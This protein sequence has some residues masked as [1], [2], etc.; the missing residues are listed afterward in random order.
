MSLVFN[1]NDSNSP[2]KDFFWSSKPTPG[3]K[4]NTISEKIL[5]ADNIKFSRIFLLENGDSK[6]FVKNFSDQPIN[7][8][9]FIIESKDK[10]VHRFSD[11]ILQPNEEESIILPDLENEDVF[12]SIKNPLN[13]VEN[14]FCF[15]PNKKTFFQN[16]F[17]QILKEKFINK[18]WA[19]EI[20]DSCISA[21][22][23]WGVISR[24]TQGNSR[25]D[26]KFDAGKSFQKSSKNLV[27][28]EIFPNPS[29]K[30]EEK[31]FLELQCLAE[32]CDLKNFFLEISNKPVNFP[33]K[34]LSF[35]EFFLV[36]DIKIKNS[37]LK[38]EIFDFYSQEKEKIIIKKIPENK[39]W[40][41]FSNY[42]TFTEISTP[43]KENKMSKIVKNQEK[44]ITEKFYDNDGDS[45][46]DEIEKEIGLDLKNEDLEKKAIFQKIEDFI[47]KN[48]QFEVTKK[49][50]KMQISGQTMPFSEINF[51]FS[52]K[53]EKIFVK[54]GRRGKFLVF[55]DQSDYQG[56]YFINLVI[57]VFNG[58]KIFMEKVANFE[59]EKKIKQSPKLT[60]SNQILKLEIVKVLPNPDGKDAGNEKIILKNL[61]NFAGVLRSAK[62]SNQKKIIE[63]PEIFFA[64]GEEKI[65]SG[66]QIPNLRNK[67]GKIILQNK[68]NEIISEV[69]WNSAKDG[70]WIS[71]FSYQQNEKKKLDQKIKIV[72]NNLKEIT[73]DSEKILRNF[74]NYR[75]A[76]QQK[77]F[78]FLSKLLPKKQE[79]LL[80]NL[81]SNSLENKPK[82]T[83]SYEKIIFPILLLF[84]FLAVVPEFFKRKK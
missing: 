54:T 84:V 63:I 50:S 66:S 57:S 77:K 45:I 18:N 55:L 26:F 65:F 31:E 2:N 72:K 76:W 58:K 9:D 64:S 70:E 8:Q 83:N 13:Q 14:F 51:I 5:H 29:G 35:Q 11:K 52:P 37:D 12:L 75:E 15:N 61:E 39:S 81:Q 53:N 17:H 74:K 60:E 42:F 56:E 71:K 69:S 78:F 1:G 19:D 21:E 25:H 62:F 40:S 82:K 38:V 48:S 67:D 4:N 68:E 6:I 20:S 80:T 46:P 36:P 10:M 44:K 3:E 34:I 7:L 43:G 28:S 73:L 30:D 33:Q 27:I 32:K 59:I 47:Q 79:D 41:R 24:F 22:E 16:N 49:S 23:N